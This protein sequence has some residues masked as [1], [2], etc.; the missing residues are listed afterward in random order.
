MSVE[1]F[2]DGACWPNPGGLAAYGYVIMD[3]G[4]MIGSGSGMVWADPVSNNVAEY[5]GAIAALTAAQESGY[6]NVT[7]YVDSDLVQCQVRDKKP[8]K[9]KAA[10]LVAL[11]DRA[12][13]LLK[14]VDGEIVWVPR[15]ENTLADAIAGDRI[16]QY[17]RSAT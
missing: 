15:E 3:G 2:S 13:E 10:H 4:E 5:H 8:W 7:L 1:L 17:K 16:E 14:A 11:R 9:C 12:R 6:T